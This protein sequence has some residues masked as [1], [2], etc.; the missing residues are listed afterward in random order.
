LAI[1][2][3]ALGGRN[4]SNHRSASGLHTIVED[5]RN[6]SFEKKYT[7]SPYSNAN[8]SALMNN[9]HTNKLTQIL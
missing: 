4:K 2:V 5:E 7:Q 8:L 1:S 3:G 9:Y 6:N